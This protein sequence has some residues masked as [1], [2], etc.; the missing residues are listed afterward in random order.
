MDG[1]Y[2]EYA[3][4]PED[5]IYAIPDEFADDQVAPLMCAGIIGY[6]AFG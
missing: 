3:V 6:S 2:A 5:F 1:G 4:A